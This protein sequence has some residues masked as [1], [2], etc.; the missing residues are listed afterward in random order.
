MAQLFSLG[1]LPPFDYEVM[2]SHSALFSYLGR[3]RDSLYFYA[4]QLDV[5]YHTWHHTLGSH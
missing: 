5:V 3:Q 4:P 2:E 1:D